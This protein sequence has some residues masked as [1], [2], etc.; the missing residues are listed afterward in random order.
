MAHYLLVHGAWGGAWYWRDTLSHLT[1]AGHRAHAVTLTGCG[2]RA[3]L[4]TPAIDLETHIADVLGAN[5]A[6]MGLAIDRAAGRVVIV[7]AVDN[8]V[9]G[10]AG[11]AVQCINLALGLPERAGLPTIGVAP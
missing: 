1:R 5:T 3:H 10:T 2:E 8:L 11:A 4:L 7:A 6:I 9:K